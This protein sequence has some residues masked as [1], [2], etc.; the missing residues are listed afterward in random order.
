M[1]QQQLIL[2]VLSTIIVGLAIV[3]GIRAFSENNV[4]SN[5]DAMTQDMVRIASDAQAWK[6]KPQAFGGSPD[7]TKGDYDDYQILAANADLA[8]LGY[9]IDATCTGYANNNGCYQIAGTA[10]GLTITASTVNSTGSFANMTNATTATVVV[11]GITDSDINQT[12]L[13]IGNL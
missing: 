4:K 1:G 9:P 11:D 8:K 7:A 10:T 3:V 2:L 6:V 5:A 13:T 12:A